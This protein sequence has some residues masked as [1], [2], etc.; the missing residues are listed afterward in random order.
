MI[1]EKSIIF[2]T[3]ILQLIMLIIEYGNL[4]KKKSVIFL[5]KFSLKL[6]STKNIT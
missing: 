6:I 1:L 3:F 4:E 5:M 2:N